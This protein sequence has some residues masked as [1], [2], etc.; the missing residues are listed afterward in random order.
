M[1]VE[2]S[3]H[4]GAHARLPDTPRAREVLRA[5]AIRLAS[6][7]DRGEDADRGELFLSVRLGAREHYGIPYRNLEEIARPRGL[8]PVPRA[9][10][11]IA[12]IINRQ[13]RL[14]TVL[15]MTRLIPV[16]PD[17]T[18]DADTRRIVVVRGA[19]LT[20]GLL[21]DEVLGNDHYH[22]DRLGAS[23]PSPGLREPVRVAGVH[24]GRVAMLDIEAM[25]AGL[26]GPESGHDEITREE[27][28]P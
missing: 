25:L 11:H 23:L 10:G 13:G 5:R 28:K 21:V 17:P 2:S 4:A 18:A 12:G 7:R 8:T 6:E 16:D 1:S 24:D 3:S 20:V 26:A 15:A 22:P 27:K 9:P 14:I 19:G